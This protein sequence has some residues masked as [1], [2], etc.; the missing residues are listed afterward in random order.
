MKRIG[1]TLYIAGFWAACIAMGPLVATGFFF[2]V[3]YVIAAALI[4][5][6]LYKGV[7]R[8]FPRSR[9]RSFRA[10]FFTTELIIVF[11][12]LVHYSSDR[13]QTDC[14][15]E[16]DE[17]LRPVLT[18]QQCGAL[19][20][21]KSAACLD[22][23]HNTYDI[24][25]LDGL[26]YAVSGRDDTTLSRIDPDSEL[27]FTTEDLG[28]GNIQQIRFVPERKHA[29]LPMWKKLRVMIYDLEKSE[30]AAYA[31]TTEGKLIEAEQYGGDFFILS[32][33]PWLY[34][35]SGED[36]S[37]TPHRLPIGDA[38]LYDLKIDRARG[39]MFVSD[40]ISGSVYRFLIDGMELDRQRFMPFVSTGLALDERRCELFVSRGVLGRIDML[41]CRTLETLRVYDAGFG[42]HEIALS[43]DGEKIY[44]V[45]YFGGRFTEIDRKTG[46]ILDEF[47]IGDQ[48]R[49]LLYTNSD[50]PRLFAASKCGIYEI[51]L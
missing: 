8:V 41:D 5:V 16:L 31:A 33:S 28:Y 13:R 15:F 22:A 42:G 35:L 14:G 2:S 37:I 32:E 50:P 38:H 47:P 27:H 51:E 44:L 6:C 10:A 26:L 3:G 43:R 46:E 34:V 36:Y 45:K 18:Y 48:T 4:F 23:T 17:R 25:M 29:V 1:R 30:P 24:A 49:A 12:T 9:F 21:P 11:L 40:W 39:A 7:P 20:A 19:R